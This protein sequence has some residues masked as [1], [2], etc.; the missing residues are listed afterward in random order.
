MISFTEAAAALEGSK[1]LIAPPASD[2]CFTAVEDDS[3]KL[4]PG[5]LFAAIAGEITDGHKYLAA[6]AAAGAAGVLVQREL[7]EEESAVLESHHC[8]CLLV[9]D[10]LRAFQ[11]LALC[12][13]EH[14]S[15]A[16]VLAITG[17]C[18][19]T[20]T[21][22]MCA[23]I[24]EEHF[25]GGVIKTIGSTNNHFGVP[26]NLFRINDQTKV[27]VIEMG[28]NHP[29]EIAGLVRLAPPD[30]GVV[31]N[32]GHAHLEF[33]HDLRGVAAEKGDLLAGTIPAG[34]TVYPAD[35]EGA[36]ILARKAAPRM[37][38]TFGEKSNADLR[39]EYRGYRDG[40]FQLMLHWARTGI[41]KEVTW[42]L[43][44]KHMAANAAAAAAAATALGCTPEEV[45]TGL[46]KCTLPGGRLE[47]REKEGI[48]Y[49]NDAFNANPDSMRAALEWFAEVA[50]ETAPQLLVLGDMLELGEG[51]AEAHAEVLEYAQKCCPDAAVLTVGTQMAAAAAQLR[52]LNV[53]DA[54]TAK[55]LL[56]NNL[57]PGTWVLLK[58][59]HG[60]RLATLAP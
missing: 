30:V 19:K 15:S 3:R 22:E 57:P 43:G 38:L 39:Y 42:N 1:W 21:K 17:S 35:A 51:A 37:A 32:I 24:L 10:T 12:H 31:C 33:F 5:A 14:Y 44:G 58:S 13:R 28:T 8:A 53:P 20:S 59:S 9:P 4:A 41:T 40:A 11:Q 52:L 16:L 47:I 55:A 7:T 46:Q 45:V 18:G 60:I 2:G 6:A 48:N 25:P 54:E 56:E 27:A 50:P 23:A 49:V 26:R 34:V 29:G 36:D